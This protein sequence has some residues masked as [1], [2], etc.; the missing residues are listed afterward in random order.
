MNYW[1]TCNV[2]EIKQKVREETVWR[3]SSFPFLRSSM[4]KRVALRNCIEQPGD[5]LCLFFFEILAVS[6]Y[7]V[8]FFLCIFV[9][10]SSV[11]NFFFQAGRCGWF[12]TKICS[13]KHKFSPRGE[14]LSCPLVPHL[15]SCHI[16]L[17]FSLFLFPENILLKGSRS[18]LCAFIGDAS[19]TFLWDV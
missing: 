16:R 11:Q 15:A 9:S 6:C 4:Q 19:P 10:Y 13:T 17:C 7:S 5:C 1:G 2:N 8:L 12:K 3:A 18:R 14:R